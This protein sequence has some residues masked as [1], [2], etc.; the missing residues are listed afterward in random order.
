M[1]HKYLLMAVTIFTAIILAAC[2]TQPTP[3]DAVSEKEMVSEM[4]A[5]ELP[6][7]MD[8]DSMGED[9]MTEDDAVMSDHED[10]AVM[11]DD[12]DDADGDKMGD[13]DDDSMAESDSDMMSPEWFFEP[14]TNA[15]N[16]ETFT[17]ADFKGKVVLVETLAMWCSNCLKQQQQVYDLHQMLDSENFVSVGIDIDPNES[18]YPQQRI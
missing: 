9:A 6:D 1:K 15:R 13:S 18:L 2:S 17:I 5:D 16:G 11:D 3:A 14:L 8:S 7:S 4:M 12:D 10:D